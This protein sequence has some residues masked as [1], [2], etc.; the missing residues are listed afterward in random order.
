MISRNTVLALVFA[1]F[2]S[3]SLAGAVE[4]HWARPVEQ[5]VM[6]VYEMPRVVVTG[7]VV[8]PTVDEPAGG[9]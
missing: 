3:L 4:L 8:R 1:C 9:N 2:A 5:T 7:K 6:P